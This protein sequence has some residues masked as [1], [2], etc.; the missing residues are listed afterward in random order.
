MNPDNHGRLVEILLAED[1]P[2]DTRLTQEAFVDG[3]VRNC[4]N[5][6]KLSAN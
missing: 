1:N 2:G 5:V 3:R 4:L 6:V